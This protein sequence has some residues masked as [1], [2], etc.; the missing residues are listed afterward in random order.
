MNKMALGCAITGA[1][2]IVMV[3]PATGMQPHDQ[4]SVGWLVLSTVIF[5]VGELYLSPVGLSF[6][7]QVAPARMVSMLMG[8]WYLSSFFGN[9][10]AGWLGTFYDK[11][12]RTQ[13]F[14]WMTVIGVVVG[15][16][17]YGLNRWLGRAPARRPALSG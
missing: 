13:F 4:L 1:G 10:M 12:P 8:V 14:W 17:L 5:T 7:S 3:V 15:V 16:L 11:M 6:V 9:Y 2:F